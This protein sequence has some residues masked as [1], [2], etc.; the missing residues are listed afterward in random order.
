MN[1]REIVI[2]AIARRKDTPCPYNIDF[3]KDMREKLRHHLGL[4]SAQEVSEAV[5]NHCAQLNIG[6][7]TG[8]SEGIIGEIYPTRTGSDTARDDWGVLWRYAPGDDIGVV[9][10]S[11]LKEPSLAGFV[12]PEPVSRGK[13]LASFCETHP[14]RYRL[15][16]LS[17]PIFQRAWFLRGFEHFLM[18]MAL[19][20]DFV[21]ELV[22]MIMNYTT[23]VVAEALSYD[24]DGLF[25]MD[26]WGQQEGLLISPVM[27][28]TY[29]KPGMQKLFRMVKE[30]GCALFFHS[31]G[32]IECLIPELIE[33]GVDVL[34]PFQPE[35][36]DVYQIKRRYGDQLSFYGGIGTQDLLP[37]GTVDEVAA[38]VKEK[39]RRLGE[40][41]GYLLAPAHALQADV[42]V[43]N[44]LK[45]VEI[46][47]DQDLG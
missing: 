34:N 37:H 21:H 7:V 12:P 3:T 25:L 47:Q 15:V 38:D 27:W 28:R 23:Q 10:D 26:D 6:S 14:D 17:S 39:V 24:I 18:D 36:M 19:H 1:K 4:S 43:E 20:P 31:C 5:G 16:S 35:V 32:D 9:A 33:M 41:G 30:K 11:P 44:V 8:P 29:F 42:P 40:H 46:M 2:D 45:L 13:Y 22:E